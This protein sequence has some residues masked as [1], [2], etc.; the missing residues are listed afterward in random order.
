MSH[1]TASQKIISLENRLT[2]LAEQSMVTRGIYS[3]HALDSR[4]FIDSHVN[5]TSNL[6]DWF[7]IASNFGLDVDEVIKMPRRHCDNSFE[8]KATN[9]RSYIVTRH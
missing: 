7:Q 8:F 5:T 3:L 2:R 1:L 6:P 4:K 9:G